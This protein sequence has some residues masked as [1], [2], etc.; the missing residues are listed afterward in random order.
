MRFA[1]RLKYIRKSLNLTQDELANACNVKL[2]AISKY[3]NE[4]IKPGFD[5]LSKLGF[6]YNVNLNW[7]VNEIG[8]MFIETPQRKLIKNGTDSFT[9]EVNEAATV[10]TSVVEEAHNLELMSDIKVDYYGL[11]NENYTK[12]YHKNGEVEYISTE[13]ETNMAMVV[14]KLMQICKNKNQLE[15]V[16]TAIN[17]IENEESLKE[18]KMLILVVCH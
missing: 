3:E 13:E 5:M 1:E 6:A 16:L 8:N 4:I 18:L 9:V 17:A 7:L 15:F 2:T 14:E 11:E 12:I 10:T